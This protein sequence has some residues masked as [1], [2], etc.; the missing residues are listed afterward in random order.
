MLF[1]C[2][3]DLHTNLCF[4]RTSAVGLK[5]RES[6]FRLMSSSYQTTQNIGKEMFVENSIL[7]E[8]DHDQPDHEIDQ[9]TNK[10]YYY[11]YF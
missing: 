3:Y 9:I 5:T 10:Q 1:I 6:I 8:K 4:L 7:G 2:V 11:F